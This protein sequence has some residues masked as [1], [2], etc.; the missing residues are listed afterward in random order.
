M[1]QKEKVRFGLIGAGA[2]AQT[3]VQAFDSLAC[4]DLVAVA[5]VRREAADAIASSHHCEA[6]S[7][8]ANRGRP[9]GAIWL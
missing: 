6:K 3:Y 2:I 4:A 7:R 1:L 5:D 8:N 9:A